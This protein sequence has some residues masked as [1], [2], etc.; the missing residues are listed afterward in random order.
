M[1][2]WLT[3]PLKTKDYFEENKLEKINTKYP[4]FQHLTMIEI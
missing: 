4:I 1:L 3:E 2:H